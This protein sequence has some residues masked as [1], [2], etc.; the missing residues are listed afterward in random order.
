MTGLSPST[1]AKLDKNE[2]INTGVIIRIYK[3]LQYDL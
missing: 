3:T 1:I 2:V